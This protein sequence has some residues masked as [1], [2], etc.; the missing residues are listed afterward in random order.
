MDRH[1]RPVL[2]LWLASMVLLLPLLPF[3]PSRLRTGGFDD[4]TLPS[5]QAQASLRDDLEFPTNTAAVFFRITSGHEY[6]EPGARRLIGDAIARVS[7]VSGVRQV[8]SPELNSRQVGRSGRTVYALVTLDT[9]AGSGGAQLVELERASSVVQRDGISVETLVVSADSFFRDLQDATTNDLQRAELVTLPIA[10]LTLL[11]VFGSVVA[12]SLPVIAGAATTVL[13]LGGILALSFPADMSVFTL[14]LS[15]MLALGLGTDYALFLVS[16][17][18]EEM[19][20]GA[21]TSQAVERAV[22]TAGRAVFFSAGMVLAGL[23]GLLSF[24][25]AFLRSLGFAGLAAVAAAVLVSMTLLPALLAV[26]GPRIDSWRIWGRDANAGEATN[27]FWARVAGLVLKRPWPVLFVSLVVL[28]GAAV[29]FLSA[30]LST[31]DARI[32]PVDSVSRRAANLMAEE[33]DAGDAAPLLVVAHAPGKIT[34][35]G[36]LSVLTDLTR[37]LQDDPRVARVDSLVSLDPRLTRA[38]YELLYARPELSPDQWARGLANAIARGNT[39]LLQVVPARDPLGPEIAVLVDSLRLTVPAPGWRLEV[40][41]VSASAIDLTRSL[42]GGFPY[43]VALILATTY[44]LLFLTF[45]SVLL[46]VKAVLMNLLSLG[47]SYGALVAVFQMGLLSGL[48]APFAFPQMGYVEATLPIL[49]FCTLF[50][51]SMD[52]EVFLLSRIRE[53]FLSTGDN[54]RS[55]TVGLQASGRVITG[56][57]AIVVAV[58]GSFSL[59]ADV[60]QIK[61]LGLGIALAVLVDATLVRGLL[62]P[63]T[64]HLLGAWNWWLPTW[65]ARVFGP[66]AGVH[67]GFAAVDGQVTKD[68][69]EDDSGAT[70]Q[71]PLPSGSIR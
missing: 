45:R 59:A 61:A 4:S 29:P 9:E 1:R 63:A 53:E 30:R 20:R 24:R 10:A 6:V 18:R 54:S 57:A 16:R 28:L 2:W 68:P 65:L 64:L 34:E 51:L 25:I 70:D 60:V 12:A 46:P 5:A 56:A 48:P 22:A 66:S 23:A 47:A 15:S 33:F 69:H 42:Y 26:L 14:N 44:G 36:Q 17:F 52:Y 32:L 8:I 39:T 55:V 21:T 43:V 31:P 40:A 67:S 41:G 35:P 50:G 71:V 11:L 62:V 37:A 7:A 58:A 38:Q 27:G 49:L 3:L 13:G 19:D